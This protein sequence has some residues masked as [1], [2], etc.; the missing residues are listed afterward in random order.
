MTEPQ[1]ITT[2]DSQTYALA[3]LSQAV[4]DIGTKHRLSVEAMHQIVT[5]LHKS[6]SDMLETSKRL[7]FGLSLLHKSGHELGDLAHSYLNKQDIIIGVLS[8]SNTTLL[9]EPLEELNRLYSA[10][11]NATL[12][13]KAMKQHLKSDS[14]EI[15]K[16]LAVENLTEPI[17]RILAKYRAYQFPP[18]KEPNFNMLSYNNYIQL[19]EEN[20][21]YQNFAKDDFSFLKYVT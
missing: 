12:I 15:P 7:N 21:I 16:I 11:I 2:N 3:D 9:P 1:S 20:E 4:A 17:K 14:F 5:M 6:L 13:N 18:E 19:L 10:A 8:N